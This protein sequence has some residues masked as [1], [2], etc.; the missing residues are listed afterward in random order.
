MNATD[1]MSPTDFLEGVVYP[2]VFD[3]LPDVFPEFCWTPRGEGW[4]CKSEAAARALPGSPRPDRVVCNRPGGFLVHGGDAV[5]WTAYVLNR[6]DPPKGGDFVQA[7]RTLAERAGVDPSALDRDLSPE[8]AAALERKA[9]RGNL[10]QDFAQA[11]R[12]FLDDDQAAKACDY[13]RGRGFPIETWDGPP[14]GFYPD[15]VAVAQALERKGWTR[16]EITAS[17]V[18]WDGRWAGRIVFPCC[19]SRGHIATFAARALEG[20]DPGSK[21][22]YLKDGTKP[23]VFGLH[24]A[25]KSVRD[26]RPLVVLE[27]VLDALLLQSMGFRHVVALGGSGTLL[28]AGRWEALVDLG[29]RRVVLSLDQDEAGREGA[30]AALGNLQ[31]LRVQPEVFVVDPALLQDCKDPDAFVR[32]HGLQAYRD[33]VDRA[34]P[35]AVYVAQGF[36]TGLS[37]SSPDM[38]RRGAVDRVLDLVDGLRGPKADLDAQ[39]ALGLVATTTGYARE[40]LQEMALSVV[41][42]RRKAEAEAD[43][44]RVLEVAHA[45]MTEGAPALEVAREASRDLQALQTTTEPAPAPFDLDG[46]LEDL[47]REPEGLTTGWAAVDARGVRFHPGE[48]TVIG[49]RPGHAK[50]T[51]LTSLVLHWIRTQDQPVVFWSAEESEADVALRLLALLCAEKTGS[52]AAWTF[53]V[54][55]AW[56]KSSAREAR[57]W[58]ALPNALTHA[59]DVLRTLQCR[60]WVVNRPAWTAD[61]ITAWATSQF[62][63]S[64]PAAVAIDYLQRIRPPDGGERRDIEVSQIGRTF[65]ALAQSL[66]TAV[67]VAAQVNRESIPNGYRDGIAKALGEG[68][69]P[70]KE[71]TLVRAIQRSAP[72]LHNLR[73]GGSEAEADQ[74]LGLL[75]Y[76]ADVQCETDAPIPEGLRRLDI[77]ILKARRGETGKWTPL[78]LDGPTGRITDWPATGPVGA[79]GPGEVGDYGPDDDAF[80][81]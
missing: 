40:D 34:T 49:A 58:P 63:G 73:E 53:N 1:R 35:W 14:F 36:L 46:L 56:F 30:A 9:R 51:A 38:D 81:Q 8:A 77:G 59:Q 66:G 16:D 18:T 15:Q 10:L 17:G 19:D 41:A 22:L 78:R 60:L 26:G 39:D 43:A 42:R 68:D 31:A 37:P 74:V 6:N 29:I 62:A 79:E 47:A 76:A 64:P 20:P 80:N 27:G 4:I 69:V 71:S 57:T 21:Y 50:T 55:R 5:A 2:A 33:L 54:L 48:L 3:R 72:M 45:R 52:G 28:N 11:C 12:G 67:V 44:R 7:V 32:A 23:A 24:V 70:A 61:Q 13:L 75:N 65:K 25:L